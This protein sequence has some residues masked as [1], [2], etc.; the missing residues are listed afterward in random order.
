MYKSSGL[1]FLLQIV[2]QVGIFLSQVTCQTEYIKTIRPGA[3]WELEK[4]EGMGR[5]SLYYVTIPCETVKI[6]SHEYYLVNV[7]SSDSDQVCGSG[8]YAREDTLEKRVYFIPF[9]DDQLEEK[10]IIDYSLEQGDTFFLHNG[11]GNQVVD[12]IRPTNFYGYQVNFIDFG[13]G[14]AD[15][16]K[17]VGGFYSTGPIMDCSGWV[18]VTDYEYEDLHCDLVN[19]N[20]SNQFEES[21]K[22]W[23]NPVKDE[24]NIKVGSEVIDLPITVKIRT[25]LGE[26][27]LEKRLN[28][29]ES[30][31]YLDKMPKGLLIIEFWDGQFIINKKIYHS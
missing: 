25:M 22:I 17:E 26:L 5:Y 23:P 9:E 28:Q 13:I 24:L 2:F 30:S 4:G 8:G 1:K 20:Y 7:A 11:W 27:I 19:S 21:I 10:L 6:D 16:F 12:T 15:G 3:K 31:I 18:R 29:K 14:V